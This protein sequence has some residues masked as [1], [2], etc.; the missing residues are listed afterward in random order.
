MSTQDNILGK[1]EY[2]R[3]LLP[4][5]LLSITITIIYWKKSTNTSFDWLTMKYLA[6]HN[7]LFSNNVQSNIQLIGLMAVCSE[8]L[9]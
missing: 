4:R 1:I 3:S 2:A 5:A 8:H 6:K 9:S 7:V